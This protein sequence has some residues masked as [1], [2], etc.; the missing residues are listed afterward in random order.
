VTVEAEPGLEP[1]GVA[2]AKADGQHAVIGEKGA[3]EGF[4]AGLGDGNLEP[5]LSGIAGA[6]DPE[7]AESGRQDGHVHEAHRTDGRMGGK[8]RLGQRTL[9]GEKRAVGDGFDLGHGGERIA[10]ERDVLRLAGGIDD[11]KEVVAPVGEHE[12]VPDAA[13][14]VG[15]QAIALAPGGEAQHVD[16]HHGFEAALEC[17][18]PR[19]G[20]QDDLAHVEPGGGTRMVVFPKHAQRI[21]DRHVVARERHHLRA[22][23]AVKRV[24]RRDPQRA[25]LI[26]GQG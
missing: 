7:V 23:F 22:K 6:G 13:S 18:H 12:V 10:N 5:V 25:L 11:D 26:V 9:Q 24:Q 4:G 8:H 16:R 14:I 17:L 2:G 20:P 3:G 15:E 19:L 1:E 21:L